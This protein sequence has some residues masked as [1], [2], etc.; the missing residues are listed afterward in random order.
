[1]VFGVI[2]VGVPPLNVILP[3]TF[4][5]LELSAYASSSPNNSQ[6]PV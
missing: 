5:V 6:Y 1:V 3:I 2:S 4:A